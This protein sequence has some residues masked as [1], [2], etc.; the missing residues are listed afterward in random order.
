MI[1]FFRP[2][3]HELGE[4]RLPAE[5]DSNVP[6]TL[7][8]GA[9][10]ADSRSPES[11][12]LFPLPDDTSGAGAAGHA[13]APGQIRTDF[14]SLDRLNTL[15]YCCSLWETG[16]HGLLVTL[17]CAAALSCSPLSIPFP[18]FRHPLAVSLLPRSCAGSWLPAAPPANPSPRGQRP[19]QAGRTSKPTFRHCTAQNHVG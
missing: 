9:G 6:P 8:Y 19:A 13:C 14:M 10:S 1:S 17:P 3:R 7:N 2:V 16:G 4:D 11:L 5:I 15:G 18:I 12:R